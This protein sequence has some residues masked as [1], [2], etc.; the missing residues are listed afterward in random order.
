M[1]YVLIV[2]NSLFATYIGTFCC[3]G[4]ISYLS[5]CKEGMCALCVPCYVSVCALVTCSP[6]SRG[7]FSIATEQDVGAVNGLAVFSAELALALPNIVSNSCK[8]DNR[9]KLVVSI[10]VSACHLFLTRT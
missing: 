6:S 7:L 10:F 9:P 3:L 1:K 2:M 4:G 8:H 5:V